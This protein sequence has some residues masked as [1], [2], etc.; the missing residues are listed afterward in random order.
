M[1]ELEQRTGSIPESITINGINY[2]INEHPELIA[3]MQNVAKVEKDKLYSRFASLQS[4]VE[5]LKNVRTVESG[6]SGNVTPQAIAE[7]L[8]GT[9]I[10]RE[11]LQSTL[12]TTVQKVVSPI[13]VST[14]QQ[15]AKE[16]GDYKNSLISANLDKCIP[17]LVIGE[18]KEE[19]DAAL[20]RSIELRSK[21]PT[22]SATGLSTR[23]VTDPVI[24]KTSESPEWGNP[25]ETRPAV[26]APS[27]TP[28]SMIPPKRESPEIT[29]NPSPKGMSDEEFAAKRASIEAELR[30]I[31]G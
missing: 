27:Q 24:A 25:L 17:E 1:T 30:S 21:Y 8:K 16:I 19:L 22:P 5:N 29:G 10:T 20:R 15:H 6:N 31:Y 14:E 26:Q 7:A 28:S 2:V 23:K 12:E 11:E 3:F 9:F 18:T 4:Q 13:L